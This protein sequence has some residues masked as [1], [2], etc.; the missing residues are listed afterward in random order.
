M[1]IVQ[2][3]KGA[4]APVGGNMNSKYFKKK[5][6]NMLKEKYL[7]V[8][9][10]GRTDSTNNFIDFIIREKYGLKKNKHKEAIK[11][12]RKQDWCYDLWID[13]EVL[14]ILKK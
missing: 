9:K 1:E 4:K 7:K 14:G 2:I 6:I 3:N 5:E 8:N 11:E 10:I 12:I 13:A